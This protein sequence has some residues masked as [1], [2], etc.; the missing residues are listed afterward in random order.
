MSFKGTLARQKL[1]VSIVARQDWMPK[2]YEISSFT[3]EGCYLKFRAAREP[4]TVAFW[5]WFTIFYYESF[6]C[7]VLTLHQH[8]VHFESSNI[9]W[10]L[11]CKNQ[12]CRQSKGTKA[13]GATNERL[14][15][16]CKK[17]SRH[18][19]WPFRCIHPIPFPS[20]SPCARQR[21]PFFWRTGKEKKSTCDED[22]KKLAWSLRRKETRQRV[23]TCDV[24]TAA[25]TDM[26]P[27]AIKV[28]L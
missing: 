25:V 18:P 28:W 11:W 17:S 12:A 7:V 8:S 4:L 6:E 23:S 27:R 1:F 19:I 22:A 21:P 14:S 26:L 13:L 10:L 9:Y 5:N 3:T 16:S 24:F 20:R 2:K 15:D